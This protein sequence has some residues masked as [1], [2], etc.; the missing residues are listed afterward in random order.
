MNIMNIVINV[1]DSM[2][3]YFVI[4][5]GMGII[6]WCAIIDNDNIIDNRYLDI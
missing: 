3:I 4:A 6:W 1:E 2:T 5:I